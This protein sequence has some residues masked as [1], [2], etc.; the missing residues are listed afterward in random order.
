MKT[1]FTI[2]LP[3]LVECT[4]KITMTLKDW[5][6]LRDQLGS[7]QWPAS[8]LSAA[9]NECV[10]ALARADSTTKTNPYRRCQ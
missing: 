6:L 5:K 4:M 1:E 2:A 10:T 9:I 8:Q 7:S 3:D